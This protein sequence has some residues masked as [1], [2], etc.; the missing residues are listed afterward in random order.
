MGLNIEMIEGKQ[1]LQDAVLSLHHACMLTTSQT[2]AFNIIENQKG[3]AF[4]HAAQVAQVV[5][6]MKKPRAS[7]HPIR[8]RILAGLLPKPPPHQLR[9]PSN[10]KDMNDA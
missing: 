10:R 7:I 1:T 2:G 9:A 3:A 5:Q 4:I 6:A 8:S